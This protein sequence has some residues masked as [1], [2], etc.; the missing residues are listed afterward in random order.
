MNKNLKYP[1][2]HS[3]LKQ[4]RFKEDHIKFVLRAIREPGSSDKL[5][6][7][8]FLKRFSYSTLSV[9]SLLILIIGSSY[10]SL[11]MAKVAAKIPYISLFIKQEEY[12]YALLG[13]ISDAINKNQYEVIDLDVSIPKKKITV[14]LLGT[15]KEVDSMK[16]EVI[17]NINEVL[18]KNNFGRYRIEVKKGKLSNKGRELTPEEEKYVA[19]SKVLE[20][21]VLEL[22]AKNNY[23]PAFP[24]EVR[25]NSTEN[26][27][28][29]ALP[30]T[31]SK[32]RLLELKELLKSVTKVYGEFKMKI[33]SIDMK[34]REQELRWGSQIPRLISSGLMS[35]ESFKITGF[36]YSF[37]QYPLEMIFKTSVKSTDPEAKELAGE[38]MNEVNEFIQS[39]EKTKDVRY[40]EY[41]VMI[42][43]K[44][45]KLIMK[46]SE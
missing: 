34:A 20:I 30:N 40:D 26:Y 1:K 32:Q 10:L 46:K 6:Y 12:R 4:I 23:K 14:S 18:V 43:G 9:A 17:T 8:N 33:T 41:K 22:L 36:S 16:Q 39:H 2:D 15:K 5:K 38:I 35:N 7:K 13:V 11:D 25:I 45:M 29:V 44:D 24:I 42:Y 27:I 3:E 19:D 28:Y 21:K 37:H 31:E